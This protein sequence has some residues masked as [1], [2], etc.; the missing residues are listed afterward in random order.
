MHISRHARVN[1][2]MSGSTAELK[3]WVSSIGRKICHA[4][5]HPLRAVAKYRHGR[6]AA[7]QAHDRADSPQRLKHDHTHFE[8]LHLAQAIPIPSNLSAAPMTGGDHWHLQSPDRSERHS[9]LLELG[10]TP[11]DIA[12]LDALLNMPQ[13]LL[14]IGCGDAEAARHIAGKNPDM[15]VIATDLYDWSPQQPSGSSYYGQIALAWH[16]R[17]LPAQMDTPCNLVIL[18]AQA[19]LLRYLPLRAIDTVVSINP[20]PCVGKSIL[21]LLQRERLSLKIKQGPMQVAILPYSRE[22]GVMACGGCSFEHDP[23]WSR[24]LGFLLGSGLRF[25][26]GAPIQWGVDLS[27][28]SAYTGNSTQRDLYICGE[29]PE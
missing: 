18:R 7:V 26:R 3:K 16:K 25:R 15:G 10:N 19:D 23:D 17:Q 9:Y 24:G 13:I 2:C 4:L 12:K 1:G 21:D 5:R 29:L 6:T 28:I 20:E 14:E 8:P 11:D 22:L 27:R